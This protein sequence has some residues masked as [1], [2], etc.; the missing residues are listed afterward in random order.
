LW[1]S[2]TRAL[3]RPT[4]LEA[5]V[6]ELAAYHPSSYDLF[7]LNEL[8]YYP[9]SFL[10]PAYLAGKRV[11]DLNAGNGELTEDLRR[12]GIDAVG[13][14]V[15]LTAYQR[16]KPYFIQASAMD[17]GLPD[18]SADLIISTL[19]PL[20][21]YWETRPDLVR[22]ILVE[23]RR[24][25]RKSGTILISPLHVPIDLIR[26][27]EVEVKA[28]LVRTPFANLPDGLK[29]KQLPSPPWL[30]TFRDEELD[31]GRERRANFWIELVR[32]D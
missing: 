10:S 7:F 11:L 13:L 25:L 18:R 14:S 19:G 27:K 24:V 16:S 17:T 4:S 21:L 20:S 26:L 30:L 6:W 28:W 9:R 1:H 8:S 32:V 2:R 22:A 31:L 3:I 5:N 23:C 12:K 29:I 15:R